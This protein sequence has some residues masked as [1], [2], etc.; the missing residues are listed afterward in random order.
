MTQQE[1]AD[2]CDEFRLGVPLKY[3]PLG[4]TRN[5]NYR[6]TTSTGTFVIRDRYFGY[7]DPA[8]I[9]FDHRALDFLHQRGVAVVPPVRT[10]DGTTFWTSGERL[11]E[12]FPEAPG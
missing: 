1:Q 6:L 7:R 5:R 10:A 8:R 2:V 12:V 4:G 11:W 3:H 9:A